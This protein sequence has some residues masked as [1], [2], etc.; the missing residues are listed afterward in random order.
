MLVSRNNKNPPKGMHGY[1]PTINKEM[2][3]I[4]YAYGYGVANKSINVVHQLDLVPTIA[5]LLGIKLP[6]YMEGNVIQ[7]D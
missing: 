5:E 7:L 3:G 4:F 2:N 6:D 1:D